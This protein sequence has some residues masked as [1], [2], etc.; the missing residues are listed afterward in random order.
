MENNSK[1]HN[2]ALERGVTRTLHG[3]LPLPGFLKPLV[4]CFYRIGVCAAESLRTLYAWLV[5]KPVVCSVAASVGRGLRIERIPYMRGPGK[6][7]IGEKV[8]IS[9]KIGIAFSRH[10]PERPLLKIGDN[11]FIGNECSFSLAKGITIGDHCLVASGVRIQDNDG[12]PLNGELRKSRQPVAQ[13]NVKPV[14]I[15]DNAWIGVRAT[16]LKGV[17]VGENAVIGTGSVVTRDVPPNTVAAGDPA[18]VIKALP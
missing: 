7:I 3:G 18:Q 15:E 14:I 6:I 1:Q 8:Y 5:V 13:E 11:T 10:G 16:I 2:S 9:G 17:T 4:K 12:H